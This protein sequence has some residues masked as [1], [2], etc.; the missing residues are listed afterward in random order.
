MEIGLDFETSLELFG[1]GCI[2]FVVLSTLKFFVINFEEMTANPEKL[3]KTMNRDNMVG[4]LGVLALLY[5]AIIH[6]SY[7]QIAILTL[8]FIYNIFRFWDRNRKLKQEG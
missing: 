5:L 6:V 4:G 2:L 1:F 3:V 7:P 8:S